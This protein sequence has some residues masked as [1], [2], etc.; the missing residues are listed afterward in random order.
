MAGTSDSWKTTA[1]ANGY[2]RLYY[3]VALPSASARLTL[4]ATTNTP[5]STANPSAK[6]VGATEK[7][8]KLMIKGNFKN[9]NVDEFLGPIMT[10]LESNGMG[11]ATSLVG[12]T[13]TLNATYALPGVGTRTTGSGYEQ[14][15]VGNIAI[16]YVPWALIFPLIEDTTKVGVFHL[17]KALNDAGMEWQ[18][19]RTDLGF[20]PLNLVAYEISSRATADTMGSF[21]KQA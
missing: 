5:D 6:H 12:I 15:T 16:A 3:N 17:Y 10:N 18:Q 4:D 8:S 1:V 21:W 14:I 11:I 19:S 9:F 13:D 20:T 7:G 2:G